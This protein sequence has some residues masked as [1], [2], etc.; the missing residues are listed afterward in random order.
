MSL[1]LFNLT[2]VQ[3]DRARNGV[4][5]ERPI[6]QESPLSDGERDIWTDWLSDSWRGPEEFHAWTGYCTPNA[7]LNPHFHFELYLQTIGRSFSSMFMR[8]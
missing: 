7:I 2:M 5:D 1:Q 3:Q 6:I 4:R 8:L